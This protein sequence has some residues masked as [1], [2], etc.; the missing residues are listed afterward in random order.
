MTSAWPGQFEGVGG[1]E[2]SFEGFFLLAQRLGF[3]QEEGGFVQQCAAVGVC[4]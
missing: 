4:T 1:E 2:V 3:E